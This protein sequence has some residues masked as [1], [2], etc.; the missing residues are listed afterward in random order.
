MISRFLRLA[1]KATLLGL[2]TAF[3]A[4]CALSPDGAASHSHRFTSVAT[5]LHR[6][7]SLS[8]LARQ[9]IVLDLGVA[10]KQR[11]DFGRVLTSPPAGRPAGVLLVDIRVLNVQHR[12]DRI[13]VTAQIDLINFA[14]GERFR[15]FAIGASGARDAELGSLSIGVIGDLV[16]QIADAVSRAPTL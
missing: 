2:A 15:S 7:G 6:D 9:Q 1:Q 14:T 8:L 11:G 3:L 16:E 10:L 4:A 13:N 5:T 12:F